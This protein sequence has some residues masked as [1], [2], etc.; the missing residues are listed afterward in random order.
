L[1]GAE[2]QDEE[3]GTPTTV[4]RATAEEEEEEQ[5]TTNELLLIAA[6][7]NL[8]E[9]LT[10]GRAAAADDDVRTTMRGRKRAADHKIT[11]KTQ[12]TKYPAKAKQCKPQTELSE[13]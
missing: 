6:R 3:Q 4:L 11:M 12:K 8:F 2:E 10:N 1:R 5:E 13:H 9:S 7:I